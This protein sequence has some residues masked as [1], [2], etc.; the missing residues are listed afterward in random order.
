M[1]VKSYLIFTKVFFIQLYIT[2][3]GT[4][5]VDVRSVPIAGHVTLFA[6]MTGL[7]VVT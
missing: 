1:H 5:E 4:S 3:I 7:R 6:H 2:V